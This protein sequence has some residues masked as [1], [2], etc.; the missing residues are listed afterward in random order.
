MLRPAGMQLVE[1]LD[2]RYRDRNPRRDS[3]RPLAAAALA[4]YL[5]DQPR[6]LAELILL[7][8]ND[9]EFLPLL[10][11]LSSHRSACVDEFRTLVKQSPPPGTKPDVRD[12]FWKKQATA[13]ICLLGLGEQGVVWPL[14]KYSENP[15]V[16][17]FIIDQLARLGADYRTLA[18]R[19]AQ[20][21]DSS[22]RQALIL[23]LGDFDAGK[24]SSQER[25]RLIEQLSA[26]YREDPDPGVHAAA[27]WTMRQYQTA[28]TVTR[29]DAEL[30]NRR[31]QSDDKSRRWLISSQ[32]QTFIVVDG[33]VGF[34][35]GDEKAPSK[36]T[37]PYRFAMAT[38]E[39]TIEQFRKSNSWYAPDLTYAPEPDCPANDVTWSAAAAYCNWLSEK[40][41]I[42]KEQWCYEK[43]EKGALGGVNDLLGRPGIKIRANCLRRT[44]YRLPTEA[45]WEYVCRANTRTSYSFG[46]PV[47]LLERYAWYL[48]NSR[49]KAWPVGR[50][51][52]NVLGM[53]DMHGNVN[54]W[55]QERLERKGDSTSGAS[56]SID[57]REF[58]VLRGG[59]FNDTSFHV[60]TASRYGNLPGLRQGTFGFRPAR[61]LP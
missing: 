5:R 10:E 60:R 54:E 8:D 7:A 11:A 51:R 34:L 48:E 30:Q 9:R 16:R 42:P 23:A 20:E 3:E 36:V 58:R 33:P 47:E 13:A 41:G 38:N 46:E 15:S 29:L 6:K 57:A 45:E 40:D 55:C 32:G 21:A 31:T 43:D 37:I 61:T 53:F 59:A 4:D 28:E 35:M 24:L 50:L 19:L 17:S 2:A 27:G 56:E 1:P 52:P 18:D 14:L 25:Q 49:Y 22:I 26:L 44:G 39:V 12:S